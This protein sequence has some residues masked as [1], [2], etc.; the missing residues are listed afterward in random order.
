MKFLGEWGEGTP[1]TTPPPSNTGG[2]PHLHSIAPQ[3]SLH[4]NRSCLNRLHINQAG[5][6]VARLIV[7]RET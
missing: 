6:I 3:H 2:I 1:T 7:S 5:R 4:M